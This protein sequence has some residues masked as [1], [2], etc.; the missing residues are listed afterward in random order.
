MG[1]SILDLHFQLKGF[2]QMRGMERDWL[3]KVR[4]VSSK[5]AFD[6]RK[7]KGWGN[8]NS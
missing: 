3:T 2:G 1:H 4:E 7:R 8:L 5:I 6:Q